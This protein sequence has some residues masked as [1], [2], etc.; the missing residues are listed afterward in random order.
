MLLKSVQWPFVYL[1]VCP[2]FFAKEVKNFN[3]YW[4]RHANVWDFYPLKQTLPRKTTHKDGVSSF[5]IELLSSI[6]D[7]GH[8]IFSTFRSSRQVDSIMVSIAS[9]PSWHTSIRL[10]FSC[11]TTMHALDSIG[12]HRRFDT[13]ANCPIQAHK[14]TDIITMP[15]VRL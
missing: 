6:R 3:R 9:Q 7:T 1:S 4:P 10:G 14:G 15:W 12:L 2:C 5:Y 8:L 13:R 11:R